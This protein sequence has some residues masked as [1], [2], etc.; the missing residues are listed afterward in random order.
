MYLIKYLFFKKFHFKKW[1]MCRFLTKMYCMV[2]RFGASIDLVTQ[3]VN[4]VPNGKL[5]GPCLPP[6][7]HLESQCLLFSFH[8]V[9]LNFVKAPQDT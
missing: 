2:L 3:I 9:S 7:L 8:K 4:I 5:F 6:S 1:Y